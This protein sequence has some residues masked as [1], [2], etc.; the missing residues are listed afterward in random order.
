MDE[1]EKYVEDLFAH[2][3]NTSANRDLKAEILSNM[4]AQKADLLAEGMDEAQALQTVKAGMP[5]LAGLAEDT[6]TVYVDRYRSDCLQA[7]VLSS[8]VFWL[9]S[10]PAQL[11]N[12]DTF[13]GAFWK[14]GMLATI[15]FGAAYLI[16]KC[17]V[18]GHCKQDRVAQR[19]MERS[20]KEVRWAWILWGLAAALFVGC[21]FLLRFG[22]NIWFHRPIHI[23]IDG[24]Y[25]LALYL[26]PLYLL[27]LT[28]LVPLTM[29]QFPKYLEQNGKGVQDE[30]ER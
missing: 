29:A 21:E 10:L 22:S 25:Q 13:R 8:V 28:V 7:A 11:L 9:L 19:S 12:L 16:Q 4:R 14:L 17:W 6:V 1:L 2:Q 24:P 23:T 18:Q 3:P 27:L 20:R 5:S 30:S 15:V 26:M